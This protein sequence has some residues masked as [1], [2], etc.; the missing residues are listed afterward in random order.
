MCIDSCFPV[1]PAWRTWPDNSSQPRPYSTVST[2]GGSF[3]IYSLRMSPILRGSIDRRAGRFVLS[4]AT[5]SLHALQQATF[6]A[7]DTT[8]MRTLSLTGRQAKEHYGP[9][10]Y[11]LRKNG[12]EHGHPPSAR[13]APRSGV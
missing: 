10:I 4:S 12:H 13:P 1:N 6:S 8:W 11:R 7:H 9:R 2:L 3:P 5:E